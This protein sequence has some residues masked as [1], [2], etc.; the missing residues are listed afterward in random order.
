MQSKM[1]K[2]MATIKRIEGKTGVSFKITVT[3]GTDISGKQVRHY[4]TWKPEQGMTERQMQKAVQKAALDFEREIEQGYEVDNRQTISEYARY[5]IDLKERAGAKHRTIFSYR[6]LLE[7]IDQAIGHL[8]LSEL[9]PLH[10]NCFYKELGAAGVRKSG[11]RAKAS[12]DL[13]AVLKKEN[14]SRA[15]LAEKAGISPTTVTAACRGETISAEKAASIAAAL[16]KKTDSLF[17]IEQDTTPL[18][19]KSILE[20]HRFLHAVLAQAEKEMLIPYNAAAKATPPKLP[21][22]EVNY[23]QPEEIMRILDA[24]ESEPLKWRTMVHLLIVTGCRRGEIM[25]LKWE[26]VDLEN[27]KIKIDTTILYTPERGIYESETK[28]GETRQISVPAET[29]SL[30][31]EY[32]RWYLELQLANG[33]RWKNSGYLFVRDDGAPMQPDSLGRWLTNFSKRHG[34]P[35][36]NPH[37]FR[38]T[39]ASVLIHSGTDIVAVSKRLGHAKTSTTTDIYAHIIQQADEEASE[40]LAD[41]LL[42]QKRA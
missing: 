21:R 6:S 37:A 32:R 4:R 40:S 31:R 33:D 23:F 25:G 8:K 35:H 19:Q 36:I 17:A 15:A 14:L 7:R 22:R 16:G 5:V 18:S 3:K 26:K 42:R 9:R 41:A 29:I 13:L 11:Q 39:A 24:L 2:K 27:R 1:V 20:Y 34:L 38:H 30:L 12:G 10:L 28:T